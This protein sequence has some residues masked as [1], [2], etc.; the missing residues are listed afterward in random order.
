MRAVSTPTGPVSTPMGTIPTPMVNSN[1]NSNAGSF[2]HWNFSF[3]ANGRGFNAKRIQRQ[4]DKDFN[5]QSSHTSL[6]YSE[7]RDRTRYF[8]LSAC[9]GHAPKQVSTPKVQR[10]WEVV[11]TPMGGLKS[12]TPKGASRIIAGL[13]APLIEKP[14]FNTFQ[15]RW[16]IPTPNILSTTKIGIGG[17]LVSRPSAAFVLLQEPPF[18]VGIW[19]SPFGVEARS[20]WRWNFPSA[21]KLLPLALEL[22]P[23]ALKL[24]PL[25]L[26]LASKLPTGVETKLH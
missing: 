16:K 9:Q 18:G 19:M 12:P 1:A 15:R 6:K 3:N 21:L 5:V 20:H 22:L 11:S 7:L 26:E 13:L 4:W 8:F 10:Q 23:W 14:N 2:W 24:L 17:P 25:V